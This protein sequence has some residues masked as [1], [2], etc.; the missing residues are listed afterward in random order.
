M[1]SQYI[2]HIRVSKWRSPDPQRSLFCV[3]FLSYSRASWC[4]APPFSASTGHYIMPL[5]SAQVYSANI[6]CLSLFYGFGGE[7]TLLLLCTSHILL[8]SLQL[9]FLFYY[10]LNYF[11]VS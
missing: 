2:P 7:K 6:P 3:S 5:S 8:F 9:D 11:G 4:L 10:N 1:R